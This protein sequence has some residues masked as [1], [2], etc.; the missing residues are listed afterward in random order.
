MKTWCARCVLLATKLT[1]VVCALFVF[2]GALKAQSDLG[3][4]SGFVRDSSG[5][6][7]ANAKIMVRNQSGVERE[8]ATNESGY[9]AITNIPPG[10]YTITV[11]AAGFQKFQSSNNKLD[12]SAV[13]AVDASLT[14]GA[15]TQ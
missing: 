8:A 14:V 3:S 12:P 7:V 13:L 5:G 9:Y 10:L 11:E 1:V 4:I 2:S 6:S 15:T